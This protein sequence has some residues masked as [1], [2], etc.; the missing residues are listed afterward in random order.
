MVLHGG[1]GAVSQQQSAEL[2]ATLLS[3]FMKGGE[4]PLVRRVHTRVVLDQQGR[5][6]HVLRARWTTP[7]TSLQGGGH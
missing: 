1:V 7:D 6:V 4:R 3:G 2:S 5:N